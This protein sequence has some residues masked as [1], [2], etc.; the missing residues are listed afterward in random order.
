MGLGRLFRAG[1][2]GKSI[3]TKSR[4]YAALRGQPVSTARLRVAPGN[5]LFQSG[6][7]P[8]DKK[9]HEDHDG[10]DHEPMLTLKPS[11]ITF[12]GGRV[13][14]ELGCSDVDPC[15]LLL[16]MAAIGR[17]GPVKGGHTPTFK[18]ARLPGWRLNL[19]GADQVS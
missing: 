8:N 9:A 12:A 7:R 17:H 19:I 6:N 18:P 10:A 11:P 14:A 5:W 16:S 4:S 15:V 1:A 3:P 2:V 13:A